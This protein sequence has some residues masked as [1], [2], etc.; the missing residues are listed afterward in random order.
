MAKLNLTAPL[1][2]EKIFLNAEVL[3]LSS[4]LTGS[5]GTVGG[6]SLV[7]VTLLSL[8]IVKGLEASASIYNLFDQHYSTQSAATS[9]RTPS[10]RMAAT[11]ASSSLTGSRGMQPIAHH[12]RNAGARPAGVA[13][14]W[15]TCCLAW[16]LLLALL[17]GQPRAGAADA[18][19]SEYQVKAVFLFN[20]ARFIEWP[21]AKLGQTDSPLVIGILGANPFGTLLD[22]TIKDR[23]ING[24]RLVSRAVSTAA[25]AAACHIVFISRSEKERIGPLLASL[26]GR[27]VVTVS[28]TKGFAQDGG[29]INLI[30]LN[31]S[32]K[33]EI[34]PT[35]AGEAGL[36]LSSKLLAI[37][38]IKPEQK[39]E[40]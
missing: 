32:V 31:G 17:S 24:H 33:L 21:A 18:G 28:E 23:T 1:W 25:E 4:R 15:A 7:N 11:S 5:G 26:K 16:M 6:Y 12:S 13:N 35:A 30:I 37:A 38:R 14:R 22:E 10:P 36:K 19:P 34:N 2:H 29:I 9:G 40:Q 39:N 20:F 3:G 27:P 8:D